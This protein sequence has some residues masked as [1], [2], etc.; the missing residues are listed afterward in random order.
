MHAGKDFGGPG[1]AR[2]GPHPV[3]IYHEHTT[4]TPVPLGIEVLD[5]K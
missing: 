4:N 2:T 1:V 3:S 5:H